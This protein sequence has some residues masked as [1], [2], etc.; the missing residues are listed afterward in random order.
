MK[1]KGLDTLLFR[2]ST[3]FDT[4]A[5]PYTVRD[6]FDTVQDASRAALQ[7]LSSGAKVM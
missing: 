2:P 5:A 7:Y 4:F 6:F 1:I 3:V